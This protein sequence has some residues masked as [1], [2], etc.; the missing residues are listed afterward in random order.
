MVGIEH[1]AGNLLAVRPDVQRQVH[2]V[3]G[4]GVGVR[5][6]KRGAAASSLL[7]NP[8][9]REAFSIRY[10]AVIGEIL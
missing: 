3:R 8:V 1:V 9:F 10:C 2:V 4:I 7:N 5:P 6:V